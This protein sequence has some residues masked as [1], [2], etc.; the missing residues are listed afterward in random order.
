MTSQDIP[1]TTFFSPTALSRLL[2]LPPCTHLFLRLFCVSSQGIAVLAYGVL[3][4]GFLTDA[5]LGKP[6]PTE[7]LANRSLIKYRLIIQEWGPWALFQVCLSLHIMCDHSLCMMA[8]KQ[9]QGSR[10]VPPCRL[11]AHWPLSCVYL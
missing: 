4:G 6:E 1:S 5:W 8:N 11:I 3:A 9:L 7:N 10:R 2:F